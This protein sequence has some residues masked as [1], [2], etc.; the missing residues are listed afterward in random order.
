M[1]NYLYALLTLVL[2]LILN[3]L[4]THFSQIIILSFLL[5]TLVIVIFSHFYNLL[6]STV[7]NVFNRTILPAFVRANSKEILYCAIEHK[8][9]IV[10]G[11]FQSLFL[12]LS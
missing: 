2:I 12:P 7:Y 11:N 9:P 5:N 10:N 3:P 1:L 8:P 6:Y 4:G